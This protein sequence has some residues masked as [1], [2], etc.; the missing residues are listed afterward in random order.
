MNDFGKCADLIKFKKKSALDQSKRLRMQLIADDDE[1]HC[2]D[3]SAQLIDCD[4]INH[5]IPTNIAHYGQFK[6]QPLHL[7]AHKLQSRHG[8]L[9][10]V[11][12]H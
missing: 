11:S 8:S 7:N 3:L 4:A 2:M 5:S 6:F 10:K 1:G 9:E 12:L